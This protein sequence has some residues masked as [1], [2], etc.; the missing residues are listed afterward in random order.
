[1]LQYCVGKY[2]TLYRIKSCSVIKQQ[3]ITDIVICSFKIIKF[4]YL[5]V[6][7]YIHFISQLRFRTHSEVTNPPS[8][9]VGTKPEL[10][11]DLKDTKVVAPNSATL[12]CEIAP[13]SPE[14]TLSWYRDNRQ[15]KP[16]KKYT[17]SYT[18]R[19]ASLVIKD[20]ELSD[21]GRY[22]CEA[23]NRVARVDTDATLTVQSKF[24]TCHIRY[25]SLNV[26][27]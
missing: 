7:G 23:D 16:S 11:T 2:I 3:N 20:T 5:T 15:L 9:S 17:M 14:P 21:A 8:V 22:R 24:H 12:K 18:G 13:G 25:L 4:Y 6:S 1:M 26:I 10:L 27:L 19:D